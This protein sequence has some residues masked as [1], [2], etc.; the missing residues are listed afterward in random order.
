M[1]IVNLLST[2]NNDGK[3]FIGNQLE[4]YW[5]SIGLNIKHLTWHQDFD[6]DSRKLLLAQS[7]KELSE[8][9]SIDI[10]IVEYPPL[11]EY[12]IPTNLLNEASLNLVITRAN[13]TWTFTDQLLLNR[14]K[15]FA[16]KETPV[17]L[18]LNKARREV[19]ESF[20]GLLPPHNKFKNMLYRLSQFGL[21]ASE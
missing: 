12:I 9:K 13:R 15:Q 14:I 18:Y 7:L 16:E 21:T 2:V 4:E 6:K 11:N 8:D 20:T 10:Y 5:T 1:R 17:V 19:V 3:T